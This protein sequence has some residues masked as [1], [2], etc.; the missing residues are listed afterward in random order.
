MA[1]GKR[2]GLIVVIFSQKDFLDV[3]TFCS[4]FSPLSEIIRIKCWSQAATS[5]QWISW[6]FSLRLRLWRPCLARITD[7]VTVRLEPFNLNFKEHCEV[8][9]ARRS[10]PTNRCRWR[11]TNNI[12]QTFSNISKLIVFKRLIVRF[13]RLTPSSSSHISSRCSIVALPFIVLLWTA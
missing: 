5:C 7:S 1:F 10:W 4:Q 3:Q 2:L 6:K 9:C 13:L 8:A 12:C 11:S